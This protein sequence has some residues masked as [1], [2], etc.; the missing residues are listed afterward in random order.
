SNGEGRG[1]DES[2]VLRPVTPSAHPGPVPPA[3]IGNRTQPPPVAQSPAAESPSVARR[4]EPA[5]R[6]PPASK[7]DP[8]EKKGHADSR[9]RER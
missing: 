8:E 5:P 6:R 4:A 3:P 7:K 9:E 1:P 2:P